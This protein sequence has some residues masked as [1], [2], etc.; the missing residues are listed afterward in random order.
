MGELFAAPLVEL[1]VSRAMING[2]T[3]LFMLRVF[4]GSAAT[5]FSDPSVEPDAGVRVPLS[6]HWGSRHLIDEIPT[7]IFSLIGSV[8]DR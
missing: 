8:A 4:P 5:E 7:D 6:A 1:Q 3:Q 2:A